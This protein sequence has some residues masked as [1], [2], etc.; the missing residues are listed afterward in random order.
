MTGTGRRRGFTLVE[1]L[2][3]LV[4][5]VLLFG[6]LFMP[7][8]TGLDLVQMGRVQTHM[9]DNVREAMEW[10]RRDLADAVYVYP[11]PV[12][13]LAGPNA[14]L[15]DADDELVTDYSQVVFV[16]A[17][18]DADGL[19]ITPVSPERDGDGEL[20]AIRYIVK[21][22]DPNVEWGPGNT[23]ALYKQEGYYRWDPVGGEYV[24]GRKNAGVFEPG[25]PES[26]NAMTSTKNMDI[27]PTST[28]CPDCG[29][30]TVG[31]ATDNGRLRHRVPVVQRDQYRP[32]AQRRALRAGTHQ[33]GHPCRIGVQYALHG[34]PRK[35]ARL[36]Q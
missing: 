19:L 22:A 9:Q 33:W 10:I 26:E 24:F 30:S 2:V 32:S 17:A 13:T 15:G 18:R 1:I 8:M 27:V 11:S 14:T 31:Y 23:F 6:L 7:M 3:V 12:I 20:K 36:P 21:L 5:L 25:I 4:I 29:A 34:G 35:L 28:V 16:R